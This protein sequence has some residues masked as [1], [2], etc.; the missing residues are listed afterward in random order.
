MRDNRKHAFC[1]HERFPTQCNAHAGPAKNH[2]QRAGTVQRR[3]P[4]NAQNK[5]LHPIAQSLFLDKE[6]EGACDHVQHLVLDIALCGKKDHQISFLGVD[7]KNAP[8]M[9]AQVLVHLPAKT[10]ECMP[11]SNS[12]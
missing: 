5:N 4:K 2:I 7:W 6:C 9:F 3:A 10:A 12:R 8:P 1:F 11:A